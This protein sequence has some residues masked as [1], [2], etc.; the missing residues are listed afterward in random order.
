MNTNKKG[1]FFALLSTLSLLPFSSHAGTDP[2]GWKLNKQFQNPIY[3]DSSDSVTYT[4]TNQLPFQL[5]K[6]LVITKNASSPNEFSYVDNCTGVRLAS[7]ASCTVTASLTPTNSGIKQL[8]LIIGGYDN[9]RVQ[10]PLIATEAKGNAPNTKGITGKVTQSLPYQ[11]TIGSSANYTFFFIN[12]G[13][14]TATNLNISVTQ[15]YG[16]ANIVTNTCTGTLA[17]GASCTVTGS[18]IPSSTTPSTQSI[19][20]TL[21]YQGSSGSPVTE[22][23]TTQVNASSSILASSFVAPNYLPPL[24]LSG[25]PY[26]VQALFTN[27]SGGALT[28]SPPGSISCTNSI[29]GDCSAALSNFSSSCGASLPATTP[30]AACQLE[31]TLT[32]PSS[33]AP[34]PGSTYTITASVGYTGIGSPST[35]TTIGTF[36]TSLPTT[37]TINL[38]NQ[39]NFPVW[40]SLNGSAVANVSCNA[41]G[42]GC[43]AGTTCNTST[44]LCYWNNPGPNTGTSYQLTQ[45][46]G[47]NSVTIPAYNYSGIQ[48]SGNISASTGCSGSSCSQ[49]SCNNNGGTTSCAP[50]KGFSQPATQAEITMSATSNDSYD[51]EVINGFHIPISMAPYYYTNIPATADNYNCGTPGSSTA[52]NNFGACNWT[53]ASLPAPSGGTGFS[54]G[55]YWVTNGGTACNISSG[56]SQCTAGQLC[57]LY[58]NPSTNAFSQVCGNFLGYWS[59]DQ[60]CSNTGLSATVSNFFNCSMSLPTSSPSFPANAT[61]Y[62]LMA[63]QVPTGDVSPLYNSCYLSY[64][65]YNASQIAT[66]CG[67][68]DWWNSSE[69][70]GVSIQANA[71]TQSCGT[72]VDPIWTQYIQP[73]V[74]WMKATC[75]SAYVYPFDDKTSGFS[76]TNNLPNQPNSTDYTITFCEGGNT[77][78]PTGIS[79]GRG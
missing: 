3:V 65:G 72:Q 67:C 59:A 15:P 56:V 75:P 1:C 21:S 18:Y 6:P 23:T 47:T 26:K 46:G 70:S 41:Q 22:T 4:F 53:N 54:S 27:V 40:F 16:T 44:L 33:P 64:S 51:V 36:V 14:T 35:I 49:A 2:I 29:S 17:T 37:R 24:V 12:Y 5:V 68:V 8:Q 9:N 30:A 28:L 38:V 78:L 62:N 76:C 74:Q 45:S 25:T 71:A 7:K 69:T 79:E 66:C 34:T 11:M 32:I 42:A 60:V 77:G 10:L 20:A 73:M 52:T 31:A 58:Q 13:T 57:G 61:L 55:Y 19:T 39:C 48:W 63:C 50:G 43:P